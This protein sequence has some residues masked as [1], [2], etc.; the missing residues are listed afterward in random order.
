MTVT[1]TLTA[2]E[3]RV[4]DLVD[5]LLAEF[6]P[7]STTPTEFLGAQ[8]DLGLAW[9]HFP[10]GHGGLG[11]NPKLQKL[12][13]ERIYAQGAPNPMYRNPI[14]HGMTGPTVVVWGSEEQKQRYLRPL[15]TG[16]EVWC[17]L[18]SE[19]GSGSDFAGLSSKGVRDGDEWVVNGQ[20]V[21]TS[22]ARDADYGMLIARTDWDQPKHRGI[23]FFWFPM[24]QAGVEVR[25]LRQATGD[26]RF[27]EVFITDA[28]VPDSHRVGDL[29]AGWWVLQT[30]LAY[31][32]VAMGGARRGPSGPGGG[33]TAQ[34]HGS[35]PTADVSLVKLARAV[36]K[37]DDPQIRQELMRLHA[38]RTVNEWNAARAQAATANGGSSP[39]ASLGKLAMAQILH[40]AGHL[41]GVL[42]G[43][44]GTLDGD[45]NPRARDANYSQLNA[46]FF[47][48]GG[49]TDQIQRNII[50]ERVLGLPPE[51]RVDK[52]LPFAEAQRLARR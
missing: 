2:D 48:I 16:E 3:Q 28:R 24:K 37:A 45:Q 34:A 8:F 26:A 23:T 51:P 5:R 15:F 40:R 1:E 30:A 10:E 35:I 39:L 22:G 29:N 49:G 19:P 7:K 18:F 12:I 17:Q 50:G 43:M 42:L 4:S 27:N 21:W 44:E 46:Y 13:N 47:S 14:G 41:Q 20:K 6:P 9:V 38:H 36:G 52:D 32:R 33:A 11:L 31:E 25:P